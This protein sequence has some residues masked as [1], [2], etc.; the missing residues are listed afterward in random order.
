MTTKRPSK[1]A[2][3]PRTF[4]GSATGI[5]TCASETDIGRAM[6]AARAAVPLVSSMP[7]V[8]ANATAEAPNDHRD[9][10]QRREFHIAVAAPDEEAWQRRRRH[11]RN[12]Y[13]HHRNRYFR[14]NPHSQSILPRIT[15]G[16]RNRSLLPGY[17]APPAPGC[18]RTLWAPVEWGARWSEV[19]WT[20]VHK[21]I[22]PSSP[23][24]L[25]TKRTSGSI[26]AAFSNRALPPPR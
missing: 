15:F 22:P 2:E 10:S 7:A 16:V 11:A 24:M 18:T 4:R 12:L 9:S 3:E 8:N 23:A 26:S 1:S 13:R 20:S 6:R 5:A 19:P 14:K 17:Q 21:A 25:S